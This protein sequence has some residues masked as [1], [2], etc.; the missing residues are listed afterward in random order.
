MDTAGMEPV[1]ATYV[2]AKNRQDVEA[3][4]AVCHE[5]YTYENV[6]LGTP[7]EGKAAARVFYS[8]LFAALPDYHGDF[9]RVVY[10]ENVAIASGR[11]GGTVAGDFMGIQAEPGRTLAV[12]VVFVCTFRDGLLASDIG[13]FDAATLAT[14]A[15]I[16][17]GRLRP[18]AGDDFARRFADFWS[19]PDPVRIPGLVAPEVTARFPGTE[20]P[21]EGM[22]AYR[23]QIAGALAAAPDLRLEVLDHLAEG[24][25]V[26]IEWRARCTVGGGR[27]EFEGMDRFRLRDGRAVDAQVAYD[28]GVLRRAVENAAASAAA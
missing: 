12:P 3:A 6:G 26:V 17:L 5:Q 4:L 25:R 22:E 14:Q 24:D 7:V 1:L 10:G 13:Y 9:D 27:V 20:R 8:A 23:D 18:G 11:F 15:G 19:A 16:P 21:V 28:T 2:E